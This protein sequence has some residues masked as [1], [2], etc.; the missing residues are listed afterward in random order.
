[1]VNSLDN[2]QTLFFGLTIV[3][4][5]RKE[6]PREIRNRLFAFIHLYLF[7]NGTNVNARGVD[8]QDAL[9]AWV[10][11]SKNRLRG[12]NLLALFKG[13][14]ARLAPHKDSVFIEKQKEGIEQLGSVRNETT[15]VIDLPQK[16]LQVMDVLWPGKVNYC[17][18]VTYQRL[19]L[20]L[21]NLVAKIDYRSE[22]EFAFRQFNFDAFVFKLLED[23]FKIEAVIV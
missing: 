2:R 17:F 5:V 12:Q 21:T 7:E 14:L 18:N 20:I 6:L 8:I 23:L 15:M 3:P 4:L 13:A 9:P 22:S 19:N 11:H 1:M 10:V 16:A